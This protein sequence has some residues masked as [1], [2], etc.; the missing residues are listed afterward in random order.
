MSDEKT[1]VLVLASEADAEVV[2][3]WKALHSQSARS[4]ENSC[5]ATA[6]ARLVTLEAGPQPSSPL[7]WSLRTDKVPETHYEWIIYPAKGPGEVPV[8]GA[9]AEFIV[10]SCN[11][12]PAAMA[13]IVHLRE[14][15]DRLQRE[16]DE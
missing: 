6:R 12:L 9:D 7:P 8:N 16:G 2:R 10:H 3:K 1:T 13:E 15:L 4:L 11:T 5:G 14:E